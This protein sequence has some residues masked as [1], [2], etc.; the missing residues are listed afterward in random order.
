MPLDIREAGSN[1]IVEAKKIECECGELVES[2]YIL[3]V[4]SARKHPE[5]GT[6]RKPAGTTGLGH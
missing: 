1:V 6:R 2:G 3:E 4:A 5:N